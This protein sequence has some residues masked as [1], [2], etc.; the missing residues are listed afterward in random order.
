MLLAD[1]RISRLEGGPA[2]RDREPFSLREH[3][4]PRHRQV[5]S[6]AGD[7][8]R[9]QALDF[10]VDHPEIVSVSESLK[11]D[12]STE[13]VSEPSEQNRAEQA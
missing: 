8:V 12:R 5:V 6:L 13:A 2:N 3:E 10:L 7:I 1:L 9:L 4:P 11:A